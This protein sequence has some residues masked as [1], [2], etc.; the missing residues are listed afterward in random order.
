MP[1]LTFM[2]ELENQ[3]N[4]VEAGFVE[5]EIQ[6]NLK[7]RYI[8]QINLPMY[9]KILPAIACFV[10]ISLTPRA[11]VAFPLKISSD[12]RYL[13]DQHNRPFPILGRTAWFIIS[14]PE[15]GF[16]Y[17]IDNTLQHGYN[18]I[19]MSVITHWQ[20]GNHAP[21]DAQNNAPFLKRLDGKDWDGNLKFNNPANQLPDFL[22]PN[23]AYWKHV[24]ELL[25]YCETKGILVLM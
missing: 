10:F 24:D 19:E 4:P 23:E 5:K 13:A 1:F 3:N 2:N 18:A 8:Q 22:T 25:A 16:K 14:L 12:K 21:F 17:F 9:N 15:T 7:E 11:Q 6:V 20:M